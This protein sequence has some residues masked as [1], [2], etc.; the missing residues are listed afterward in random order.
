MKKRSDPTRASLTVHAGQRS[1]HRIGRYLTAKFCEHLGS[2][3]ANGMCAEILRNPTFASV[4]FSAGTHPPD[5]GAAFEPDL[6]KIRS[7]AERGATRLEWPPEAARALGEAFEDGLAI[8]WIRA[9]GREDVRPSPDIGPYGGRAQRIEVVRAGSGIAQWTHLPTHR[10]CTFPC[11]VTVRSPDL[12]ALDILL[13]ARDGRLLCRSR[14]GKIADEWRTFSV[15]VEMDGPSPG[16]YRFSLVSE[17]TGLFVVARILLWPADHLAGADP[18]VVKALRESGLSMLRWPGGNFVSGYDWRDGIGPRDARPTRANRAWGGVEPNLFGTDEFIAFCRLTGAEPLICVNAGTGTP[19]DAARWVEYCN[20]P[21]SHGEGRRRAQNGHP[22]PYGVRFWEVGNELYG[23]WQEGW[24][25]PRGN[26][27][28]YRRFA[29]A[30]KAADPTLRLI[31]CAHPVLT[32]DQWNRT[33]LGEAGHDLVELAD[34]VLAG[35]TVTPG[36]DPLDVYRDFMVL[37]T[38]F[39]D[40]YRQILDLMVKAGIAQPRLAI[41]EL[42]LFARIQGEV[43][44]GSEPKLT[45]ATLVVPSSMAEAV[46]DTLFWHVGARLSPFMDIITHS[47][48]VNH[49][50]GL[51]KEQERVY[52]NPCEHARAMFSGLCGCVPVATDLC[53]ARFTPPLVLPDLR[54]SGFRDEVAIVDALAA[55]DGPGDLVISLVH[56]G[57]EGPVE[58][59][60]TLEDFEPD[61]PAEATLLSAGMPWEG[62]TREHPAHVSPSRFPLELTAGALRVSLPAFSVMSLRLRGRANRGLR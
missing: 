21:A 60:I 61:A 13:H 38:V 4:P 5:G 24:T 53:S 52:P 32:G 41:T 45:P 15:T 9:G 6:Q 47:A 17:R 36:T 27:D 19:E 59:D 1:D 33:L 16:P 30:M 57:V 26:A 49:G 14:I 50:G 7:Q 11:E 29:V 43:A 22:E 55:L 10:I 48:T 23:R 54:E 8:M 31:A 44:A 28:R 20:G 12:D 34:H 56:R 35:S 3:I 40:K 39:E 25:T 62:N 51:R 37:P 58:M 2:N 46:Y 42:Q 18:D